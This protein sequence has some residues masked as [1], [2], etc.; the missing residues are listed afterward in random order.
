MAFRICS[1]PAVS[2]ASSFSK[3]WFSLSHGARYVGDAKNLSLSSSRERI[4]AP[5]LPSRRRGCHALRSFGH[6]A[7]SFESAEVC[8]RSADLHQASCVI[9]DVK[10]PRMKGDELQHCSQPRVVV[11]LALPLECPSLNA[12]R[13]RILWVLR[14]LARCSVFGASA[15]GRNSIALESVK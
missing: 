2:S 6:C 9:T 13:G 11:V 8:L 10:M 5:L 12:G 3:S 1:A 14:H 4:R 15:V 7:A